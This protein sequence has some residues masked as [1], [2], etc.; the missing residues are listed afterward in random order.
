MCG[1][2]GGILQLA[3]PW[4]KSI[5]FSNGIEKH[6]FRCVVFFLL[7]FSFFNLSLTLVFICKNSR[8]SGRY[9]VIQEDNIK[10]LLPLDDCLLPLSSAHTVKVPYP[11]RNEKTDLWIY[12][13]VYTNKTTN[14]QSVHK[15]ILHLCQKNECTSSSPR[16]EKTCQQPNHSPR[17]RPQGHLL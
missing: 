15:I 16:R 3:L 2:S 13:M 4:R 5:C 9:S 8:S 6:R 7:F 11:N 12:T 17:W 1:G 10:M 14:W